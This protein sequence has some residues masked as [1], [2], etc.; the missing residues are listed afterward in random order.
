M[1]AGC[2]N[3]YIRNR[4]LVSKKVPA[5]H[6]IKRIPTGPARFLAGFLFLVA[7]CAALAA[8][9]DSSSADEQQMLSNYKTAM[10]AGNKTAAIKY[11]L[12]FTEHT[13]GPNNPTT[14]KLMNQY[15]HSLY[16][17]GEH[18]KATEVLI[19][20]LE[21]STAVFGE[22]GDLAFDL[23]M[24][25]GYA[26]SEWHPSLSRRMKYFDRALEALR[27]R[28]EQESLE[29]VTTLVNIVV[30]LMK[31]DGL[32]G[33]YSSSLSDTMYSEDA[34][35][36]SLP[37][38][39]EY[40]NYFHKPEKYIREAAELSERL[41]DK[42][43]YLSSK[44]SILQ[45]KLNVLETA[46]LAAVPMGVG[47]YISGGTKRDY[48]D[49]EEERLYVAIDKL[50]E[51]TD[52]NRIFLDA[53]NKTLLE[54]AWLDKDEDRMLAM[55]A[56]G[57]LNSGADYAPDRLYEVMEGGMVF[58]PELN[59]GMRISTNIFKPLRKKAD[60]PKDKNGNPVKRPYFVPVCVDGQLMAYLVNKPRVTIE[61][62]R[63]PYSKGRKFR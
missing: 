4:Q 10:D 63:R 50:A 24:N 27:E 32:R 51:D 49:R 25:I 53:A 9:D 28:G 57:K 31:G 12:D 42:D 16:R 47:G 7:A 3:S 48:L 18:R 13:R 40:S 46:D 61:E 35:E 44:I 19:E 11:A 21:R 34:A 62:V 56:N 26:Y 23:N 6:P 1:G 59:L 14:I 45:A 54:I 5:I 55:C 38:E 37:I 29:Y 17:D 15:G 43:E 33:D 58:A 39:H 30:N 22:F 52:T 60:T 20:T 8:P 2:N 36:I 41:E